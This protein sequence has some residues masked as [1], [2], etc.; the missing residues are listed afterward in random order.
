MAH[1]F[2]RLAGQTD[3]VLKQAGAIVRCVEDENLRSFPSS[4]RSLCMTV[5]HYLDGTLKA[6]VAIRETLGKEAELLGQLSEVTERQPAI[7]FQL[8]ALSVHTNVELAQLGHIESDFQL[9]AGELSEFSVV[10]SEQT[11][12]L[13]SQTASSRQ[14]IEDTGREAETNLT[15]MR[16][17]ISL[18]EE[19]TGKRLEAI[20]ATLQQLAKIPEQFRD[21]AEQ[22]AKQVA[23]VVAAIQSHDITRQQ[24]EHVQH[25]LRL[26]ASTIRL[27]GKTDADQ[28]PLAHAGLTIQACQLKTIRHTVSGWVSQIKVCMAGI[29]ELSATELL[30]IGEIVLTQ[31]QELSSQLAHI[32]LVQQKS[33]D[34]GAR[35]QQTLA[36]LSG[37]LK[38]VHEYLGQSQ[39]IGDRLRILTFNSL[40][41]ANRL[42]QRGT[43]VAAIAQVIK[44]VFTEWNAITIQARQALGRIQKLAEQTEELMEAFSDAG[45]Q[46][47]RQG[48]T[49]TRAAL[50]QVRTSVALVSEEAGHMQTVTGEMQGDLGRIGAT[51]ERLEVG[52]NQLEAALN[53]L[54]TLVRSCEAEDPHLAERWDAGEAEKLFSTCYTTEIEREVMHAALSGTPLPVLQQS[55]AGNPVELF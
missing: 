52:L 54:E 49:Q 11:V 27:S 50:H 1:A 46:D 32:E 23:G 37:L 36:G 19:M 6:A 8:K 15:Q 17:E 9:L 31:E 51:G 41:E 3:V 43:V 44:E 20:D 35:V 38:L 34:Y 10:V 13:A 22:T 12:E 42:G 5:I 47:L 16:R 45:R 55:L 18:M 40:I 29:R 53:K 39:A 25:G 2:Q 48:Q 33:Q 14:T 26:I 24:L 28:L 7:A 30:G 21:C 4:M